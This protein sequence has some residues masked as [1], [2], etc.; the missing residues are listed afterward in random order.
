MPYVNQFTCCGRIAHTPKL[1]QGNHERVN[2]VVALNKPGL[3]RPYY[4]DC[5]IWGNIAKP[6]SEVAQLGEEIF[7]V[8][9]IETS[10]YVD[11]KGSWH[12][13][14]VLRVEKYTLLGGGRA[15]LS[16]KLKPPI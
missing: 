3:D 9:E 16:A 2:F 8:G 6:F 1:E 15:P 13:G 12:K 11:G 10:K 5:V 7:L 14:V 4:M